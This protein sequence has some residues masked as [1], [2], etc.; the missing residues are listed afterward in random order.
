MS[1]GNVPMVVAGL[2]VAADIFTEDVELAYRSIILRLKPW[3]QGAPTQRLIR[4]LGQGMGLIEPDRLAEPEVAGFLWEQ[5][6]GVTGNFKRLLHWGQKVAYQH[7]R[8]RG[9]RGYSRGGGV[10]AELCGAMTVLA[11][12]PQPLAFRVRPQAD[13]CFDSWIDR[14]AAA[15][16]PR[17]PRCFGTLVLKRRLPAW[18]WPAAHAACPMSSTSPCIK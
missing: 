12:E 15:R 16:K 5:S 6:L 9:I 11:L 1:E 10:A 4:V 18:I 14:V 3:P 7:G 17:D 13:E 2:D 8:A